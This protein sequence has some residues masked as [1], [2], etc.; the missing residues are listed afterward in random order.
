MKLVERTMDVGKSGVAKY[1]IVAFKGPIVVYFRETDGSYDYRS[2]RPT[3]GEAKTNQ[4]QV[5]IV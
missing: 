5:D 2:G 3:R 1:T 4:L